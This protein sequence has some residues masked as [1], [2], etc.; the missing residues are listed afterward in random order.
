MA[1]T[2]CTGERGRRAANLRVPAAT[3][4]FEARAAG[5]ALLALAVLLAGCG[6]RGTPTPDHDD[7]T[8][9]PAVRLP[10][11]ADQPWP[12]AAGEVL[13]RSDR[14]LIYLPRA[15]DQQ[16]AIAQRFLG[17]ASK[18]WQIAEANG[19]AK[20]EAGQP[21]IVPLLPLN[22]VGVRTSDLQTI[23]ILC[24]HRFGGAGSRMVMSPGNFAAQLDWLARNNYT[25]LRLSQ[26]T[27]FLAGRQPLPARSVVI[28]IDDG[29]ESV[30]R[31][32][33]PLLKKHNFPATLFVYTDFVGIGDGLNW[34][35]LQ[36]MAR[37]GLVDI[38]AHSKTHRNLTDRNPGETDERYRA[39]IETELR[40][41]RELLERRLA[42]VQVRQFAYPFGDTNEVVLQAMARQKYQ[43]GV[44]V[45]PGG[46]P[47][48][49]HP[50]TLRR[51]MIFGDTDLE[52]FKARLQ[53]T[54]SVGAP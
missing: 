18:H 50:L 45:N 21:L 20:A 9:P 7:P 3:G 32:A 35:Q 14:L 11:N 10:E 34:A 8:P 2:S 28:T 25:V 17:D 13:G 40:A 43:I 49:A 33:W 36:E 29:Y 27:E 39:A 16:E 41:P 23:P 30:Y 31:H 47:F 26:L 48:F 24:Y 19:S 42:G 37:S 54:R 38:Q 1:T 15:G 12:Q 4:R 6:S 46:N 44:T 53:T 5:A 51:T 52:G 22:P